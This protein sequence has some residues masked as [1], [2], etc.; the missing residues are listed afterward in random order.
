M[1]LCS[2][3]DEML[4][5]THH[6]SLIDLVQV[7]TIA[8]GSQVH[9]PY[10]AQKTSLPSTYLFF[11]LLHSPYPISHDFEGVIQMPCS[12]ACSCHFFSALRPV[13]SLCINFCVLY[14]K[15]SLRKAK[16]KAQIYR[17]KCTEDT[18]TQ[19]PFRKNNTNA[20]CPQSSGHSF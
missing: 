14:K 18:Q 20:P 4:I 15:V 16:S 2:V 3:Y 19:C 8:V 7:T 12:K 5:D 9:G 10:S 11:W 17:Y 1:S 6:T 13:Q